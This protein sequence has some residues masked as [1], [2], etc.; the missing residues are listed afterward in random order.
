MSMEAKPVLIEW[1]DMFHSRALMS[2]DE[3]KEKL[4]PILIHTVGF[5]VMEKDNSVLVSQSHNV[6]D[7]RFL[8]T[9]DI[10]RECI[11]SIKE[12]NISEDT[13]DIALVT[14]VTENDSKYEPYNKDDLENLDVRTI[15]SI[16]FL[17]EEGDNA[18]L[19]YEKML[20]NNTFR[21][22]L[23]LPKVQLKDTKYYC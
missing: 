15:H 4:D 10:L 13:T 1:I 5:L 18:V 17:S 11:K 9:T 8:N 7:D 16:G 6:T 21:N 19:S 12:L 23:Y 3:A 20:K 14:W 2:K 22:K